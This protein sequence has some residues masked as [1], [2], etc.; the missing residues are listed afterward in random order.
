VVTLVNLSDTRARSLT[1]QAGALAEHRIERVWFTRTPVGAV[2]WTGDDTEYLH[3]EPEPVEEAVEVDGP[4]LDV[5]LPPGTQTTLTM[6]LA[7]H[8]YQPSYRT[9]YETG[10]HA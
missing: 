8:E 2:A 1:V 7:L 5:D 9:P 3:H 4:W 6:V 10:E